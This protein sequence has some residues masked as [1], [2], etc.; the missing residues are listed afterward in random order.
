[1][2][3]QNQPQQHPTQSTQAGFTII[4]SLMALIVASILLIALAPVIVLSVGVRVQA[5][6]VERSTEAASSYIDWVRLDGS[7]NAPAQRVAIGANN[8]ATAQ[9]LK[10]AA[11]PSGGSLTCDTSGDYCT[12]P[13]PAT[14]SVYCVNLDENAGCQADSVNDLVV[15][16]VRTSID[17]NADNQQDAERGYRL[18][19]RVYRAS[20][21]QDPG[22]LKKEATQSAALGS[23]GD[24]KMPLLETTTDIAPS[25]RFEND[26]PSWQNLLPSPTPTP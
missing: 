6:R 11:A 5:K 13:T 7:E 26:L 22:T 17:L 18:G 19:V 9:N 15:Q 4:E 24:S 1:M 2:M 20:A 25:G 8:A 16:G 12:T 21:F 14:A 23:L 10:N 3:T